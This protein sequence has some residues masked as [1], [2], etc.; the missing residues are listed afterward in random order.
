MRDIMMIYG[1]LRKPVMILFITDG[2]LSSDWEIEEILIKT[3][4]FPIYWQFVGL[5]GEEYGVLERLQEIDGRR[6]E[7]AAFLK[8][9]DIDDLSDT[10]LYESLLNNL[11][12]W[13]KEIQYKHILE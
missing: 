9:D 8:L 2:R 11:E 6:S 12:G 4:R 13:L 5:H 3:S 1:A 10:A 7:N